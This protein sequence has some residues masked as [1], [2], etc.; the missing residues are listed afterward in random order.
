[1]LSSALAYKFSFVVQRLVR[2]L[3][4]RTGESTLLPTIPRPCSLSA[5]Q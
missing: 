1:M 5:R 4:E 2:L 3:F